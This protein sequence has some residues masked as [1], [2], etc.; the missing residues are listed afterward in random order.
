MSL[1]S[2]LILTENQM[3]LLLTVIGTMMAG[4]GT[5]F[6]AQYDAAAAAFPSG[7]CNLRHAC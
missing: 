6:D 4:A 7:V 2:P 5:K 3:P 1:Q